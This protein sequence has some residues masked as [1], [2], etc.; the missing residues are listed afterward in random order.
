MKELNIIMGI[1][2]DNEACRK[3]KQFFTEGIQNYL[4]E[5][6]TVH[7]VNSTTDRIEF[8]DSVRGGMYNVGFVLEVM[9]DNPIG[10]GAIKAWRRD[11]SDMQIILVMDKSR[12]ST[13][14]AKGLYDIGYYEGLFLDDI[15]TEILVNLIENGRTKEEAYAYYGLDDYIE[16][17]K[18]GKSLKPEGIKE[19]KKPAHIPVAEKEQTDGPDNEGTQEMFLKMGGS[20]NRRSGEAV[21]QLNFENEYDEVVPNNGTP[22]LNLSLTENTRD[23]IEDISTGDNDT[24]D[25]N[26]TDGARNG[27]Y[28]ENEESNPDI[29]Y[30]EDNDGIAGLKNISMDVFV[31]DESASEKGERN[32]SDSGIGQA[33]SSQGLQALLK[34]KKSYIRKSLDEITAS[35]EEMLK[36]F[37]GRTSEAY[38]G[39]EKKKNN[40]GFVESLFVECYEQFSRQYSVAFTE[41]ATGATTTSVLEEKLF[42]VIED[43]RATSEDKVAVMEMFM[44][45]TYG[46]DLLKDLIET[47]GITEIHVLTRNKIRVKK[48]NVRYSTS[49]ALNGINRY[50]GFCKQLLL[51]NRDRLT[52]DGTTKT[53]T[54]STYSEKYN[55]EVSIRSADIN[56][57]N[58]PELHIR[59]TPKNKRT[60][61]SLCNHKN[62]SKEH[63][64]YLSYAALDNKGII[65]CGGNT[66]GKTTVLN[67]LLDYIPSDKSGIVIQRRNELVPGVH[68]EISV[69]HPLVATGDKHGATYLE[70]ANDALG[71]DVEYYIMSDVKGPEADPF[72][73]ALISSFITWTCVTCV[74]PEDSIDKI[75][76]Y[77]QS[78][79]NKTPY[80]EIM[81]MLCDKIG[82]IVFMD[83]LNVS[84]VYQVKGYDEESGVVLKNVKE[85]FDWCNEETGR[86]E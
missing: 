42:D 46:Y 84:D 43:K 18:K 25:D 48:G 83:N 75:A 70:L 85:L 60:L 30:Q 37:N 28:S 67:A 58:E 66:A 62:I 22:N 55:L 59:K 57:T 32:F 61:K 29:N 10:Q 71:E 24:G 7:A 1:S 5:E 14:K 52:S 54:D 4:S 86:A 2:V 74:K 40:Q 38:S 36:Y 35:R 21:P 68:P 9:N 53:F 81:Y 15:S 20:S 49:L 50:E 64:S 82:T 45:Y 8:D 34:D 77:V 79:G 47:D 41:A 73:K 65:I 44:E 56:T 12:K 27:E 80:N 26:Y 3:I 6:F 69:V 16:P 78:S 76:K 63:A 31:E 11:N 13:G 23:I 17:V 39:V 33:D 72:Y 19:D 51:R